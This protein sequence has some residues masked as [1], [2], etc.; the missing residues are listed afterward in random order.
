ME[1]ARTRSRR[2]YELG[3][4]RSRCPASDRPRAGGLG[5][6]CVRSE[7][8]CILSSYAWMAPPRFR[9]RCECTRRNRRRYR[10]REAASARRSMLMRGERVAAAVA[11][12][13]RAGTV[14][15]AL[16]ARARSAHHIRF[17][18]TGSDRSDNR[19]QEG[20]TEGRPPLVADSDFHRSAS[21]WTLF[22]STRGAVL[23]HVNGAR[24]RLV[25]L[26][27]ARGRR[28]QTATRPR[29]SRSRRPL[30]LASRS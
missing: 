12:K 22:A 3:A 16:L 8:S 5:C 14:R 25:R 7:P 24:A 2:A 1:I 15:R 23:G 17:E 13:C 29:G 6:L 26:G 10:A 19:T 9:G 21:R 18:A 11:R 4:G 30:M 20:K 28:S 27:N